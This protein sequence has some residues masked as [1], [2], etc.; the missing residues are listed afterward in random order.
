MKVFADITKTIGNTPLVKL[1]RLGRSMIEAAEKSGALKPGA[2]VVEPTSGN[3]LLAEKERLQAAQLP[4]SS[5]DEK[6]L[7]RL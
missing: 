6:Y 3:T 5:V 2:H 7:A 1:Q 4:V